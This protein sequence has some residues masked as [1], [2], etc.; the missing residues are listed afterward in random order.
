MKPEWGAVGF[1]YHKTAKFYW[2][3]PEDSYYKVLGFM[4]TAFWDG[5]RWVRILG[6]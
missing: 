1:I 6:R 3:N 4:A 2:A 5:A